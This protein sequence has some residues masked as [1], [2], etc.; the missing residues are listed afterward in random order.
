MECNLAAQTVPG[1]FPSLSGRKRLRAEANK[2]S[3]GGWCGADAW[4]SLTK[5]TSERGLDTQMPGT[6]NALRAVARA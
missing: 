5:G 6:S 1:L 3:P 2:R 4:V